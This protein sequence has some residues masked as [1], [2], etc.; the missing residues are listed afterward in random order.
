MKLSRW[1]GWRQVLAHPLGCPLAVLA[2]SGLV[3]VMF[4]EPALLRK[5]K[6]EVLAAPAIERQ[7]WLSNWRQFQALAPNEQARL[8]QRYRRLQEQ[9]D[10]D[11]LITTLAA[12]QEWL[13]VLPA[14]KSAEIRSLPPEKR[15]TAIREEMER[16]AH[17]QLREMTEASLTEED[18]RQ[19]R[20]WLWD[21][22]RKREPILREVF[23]R[24][25]ETSDRWRIFLFARRFFSETGELAGRTGRRPGYTGASP[26]LLKKLVVTDREIEDLLERLSPKVRESIRRAPTPQAQRV[27]IAQLARVALQRYVLPSPERLHQL[28]KALPEPTRRRLERMPREAAVRELRRLFIRSQFGSFGP[29]RRPHPPGGFGGPRP[30][31]APRPRKRSGSSR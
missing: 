12:Y 18:R 13:A 11:A 23:Q 20:K 7:K 24:W 29:N 27:L 22:L 6:A 1:M 30:P 31:D 19:I 9:P 4:R 5:R 2:V 10:R 16:A 28:L 14:S 21:N 17:E 3:I 15:L 26:E 25:T 8:C